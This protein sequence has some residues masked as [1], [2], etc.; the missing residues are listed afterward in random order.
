M[1]ES[2]MGTPLK[3]RYLI[4]VIV[5]TL[6]M[7]AIADEL[8]PYQIATDQELAA[9]RGG[10]VMNDDLQISVG[11]ERV[12]YINGVMQAIHTLNFPQIG[13]AINQSSAAQLRASMITLVQNGPGNSFVPT[14]AGS[15]TL[16]GGQTFVQNTLDRQLIQNLTMIN[17]AVKNLDLFRKM[18]LSS[19]VQGQLIRAGR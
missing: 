3:V 1:K 10:F 19:V 15:N 13:T 17:A 2:D 18:N 8:T 14:N 16:P 7:P 5:F 6:V 12:I 11:I 9:M 4:T